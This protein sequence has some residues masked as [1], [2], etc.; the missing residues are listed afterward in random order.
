[1]ISLADELISHGNQIQE[2]NIKDDDENNEKLKSV[3]EKM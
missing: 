2:N 1:M 3:V